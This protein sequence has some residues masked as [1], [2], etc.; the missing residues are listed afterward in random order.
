MPCQAPS[1]L[2]S[3]TPARKEHTYRASEIQ[4]R[5]KCRDPEMYSRADRCRSTTD[6]LQSQTL[7]VPTTILCRLRPKNMPVTAYTSSVR[8]PT[9]KRSTICQKFAVPHPSHRTVA[10]WPPNGNELTSIK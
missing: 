9:A 8:S 6:S 2:R 3:H 7:Q 4:I 10:T 1:A 5:S